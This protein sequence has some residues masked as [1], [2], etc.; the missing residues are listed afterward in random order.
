[1][2]NAIQRPL[3][4]ATRP[5]A[6]A[7]LM[8]DGDDSGHLPSLNSRLLASLGDVEMGEVHVAWVAACVAAVQGWD[9]IRAENFRTVREAELLEAAQQATRWVQSAVTSDNW[10]RKLQRRGGPAS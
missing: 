10:L 7:L 6:A 4:D 5:F 2:M 3:D 9:D 1:M 8:A